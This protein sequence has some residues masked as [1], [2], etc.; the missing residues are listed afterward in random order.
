LA[1]SSGFTA[2][3]YDYMAQAL[4]DQFITAGGDH[5]V[6]YSEMFDLGTFDAD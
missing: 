1:E 5:P 6:P 3:Q 2:R 4:N